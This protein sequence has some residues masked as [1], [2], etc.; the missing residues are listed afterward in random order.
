MS[1]GKHFRAG[2]QRLRRVAMFFLDDATRMGLHV[3]VGTSEST[4]LFLRGLFEAI[5]YYGFSGIIY[6]DHGA[7]FIALDTQAVLAHMGVML[8]H[9]E[10]AYPEGHG[11]IERFHRT[12]I[13]AIL[14]GFDGRAD[15]DPDCGALELRL[16]HWLKETYNHTVHESLNGQTPWQ[17]FS[18]DPKLLRFPESEAALR[19]KFVV[20]IKRKVSND[21][22]VS[23]DSVDY[24]TPRGL[25]GST[26]QVRRQVLDGTFSVL[27][28]G[29]IVALHPVD[30]A[31]N[32]HDKRGQAGHEEDDCPV[33]PRSAAD[34]VYARDFK[35]IVGVDGGFADPE[36]K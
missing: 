33:L 29:R 2:A 30:L 10:V 21:H 28:E 11:K 4:M 12:A 20:H 24:E 14:R 23:V 32:A 16:R 13:E 25:A 17:R 36:K 35:P 31:A 26:I 22:V 9:G 18:K 6:L 15:V 8:I 27:H 1:D 34:M 7:G 19:E 3:V 5:Q